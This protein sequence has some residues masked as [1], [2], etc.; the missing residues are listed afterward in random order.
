MPETA[1]KNATLV[2]IALMPFDLIIICVS[3]EGWL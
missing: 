3:K 2:R 1:V